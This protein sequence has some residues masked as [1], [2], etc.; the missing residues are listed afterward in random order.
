[1]IRALVSQRMSFFLQRLFPILS[2][3]FAAGAALALA[4]EWPAAALS[5]GGLTVADESAS[6]YSL[7]G[8]GL[9][10]LQLARFA[11]GR[12]EFHQR[13][14]V[15]LSIAGKWGR[16]PTSN[17]ELCIDCHVNNGRGRPPETD[18]EPLASMVVRLSIPGEN[19]HGGPLPHPHYGDQLQNQGELGRVPAEGDAVIAWEGHPETLADGTSVVLRKPKLSFSGLAFGEMGA[20]TLT[21]VRI[22]PAVFGTGLL[23]AVTEQ[24]LFDIAR[25][26]QHLGFNGRL[27]YVW[28]EEKHAIAPGRFGWKANQPS[29]RQQS[30][31]AFL[32]DMGVTTSLFKHENCPDVQV[33]CR[34]RPVGMVP[35]QS[36]RA[37]DALLF[38]L[39][40]LAVPARR[41]VD[42]PVVRHGEELFAQAQCSVCHAPE[43]TIGDYPALAQLGHQFIHPYTDLLLHD[44]GEGLADGRPDFLAG[45]RDWRTPPLWG[46]GLSA[47]VNGNASLLHDGRARNLTEAVL[48]HGGEAAASRDAFAHMTATD[49]AALLAFLDSL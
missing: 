36:D 15:L 14:G 45:P 35:E 44:M 1:M 25:R 41:R 33:A 3:S 49:R 18:T 6:A 27:N 24:T 48:W 9:D 11:S 19:E 21:S 29:L 16:G 12:E 31:S 2:A 32:N 7:P 28:D 4:G 23:D 42:D 37:F 10:P 8:P 34:K 46:I 30:A 47:K 26:Q 38:Y 13:W 43:M 17:A 22:A 40:A 5:G 39:R 20:Q